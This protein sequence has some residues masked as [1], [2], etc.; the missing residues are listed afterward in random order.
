MKI[1][2]LIPARSGSRR[3]KDKNI[4]ELGG[5][6]LMVWSIITARFLGIDCFVSSDSTPYLNIAKD[7]GALPLFR[8]DS[9]SGDEIGDSSV[10]SHFIRQHPSYS[11]IVYLRPTTPFRQAEI[12]ND[13]IK[14][15]SVPGYDSLR[16]VEEMPETAYKMFRIQKGLLR[17]LTKKDYTDRPNQMLPKTYKPNGYVDIVRRDIVLS[18]SLWGAGRYAFITQETIEIDTEGDWERAEFKAMK[19]V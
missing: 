3:V 10:I 11:L 19:G 7:Y 1:A 5:K 16:S 2:A 12:V 8:P 17:P 15:M 18:G 14:L 6:P 9:L 13:A 4:R